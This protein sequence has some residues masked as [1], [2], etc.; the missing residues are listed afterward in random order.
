MPPGGT[1]EFKHWEQ[2]GRAFGEEAIP[3][4]LERLENGSYIEQHAALLGL[5]FFGYEAWAEGYWEGI[6]YKVRRPD[7]DWRYIK[8]KEKD[9]KPDW[10]SELEAKITHAHPSAAPDAGASGNVGS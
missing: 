3:V 7:Q 8:P 9:E 4:F 6:V 5:R 2:E 1:S 10:V